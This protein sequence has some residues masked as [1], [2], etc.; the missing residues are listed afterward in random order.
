M[1]TFKV[2]VPVAETMRRWWR[3]LVGAG[4]LLVVVAF[5]V[6]GPGLAGHT[7]DHIVHDLTVELWPHVLLLGL[8]MIAYAGMREV[9]ERSETGG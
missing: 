8:A 3:W 9:L 2:P 1:H 6:R 5:V 7:V 4:G